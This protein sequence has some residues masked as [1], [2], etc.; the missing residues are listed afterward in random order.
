MGEIHLGLH[1]GTITYLNAATW[2]DLM[3]PPRVRMSAQMLATPLGTAF[4]EWNRANTA[5]IREYDRCQAA[6]A[7]RRT[8]HGAVA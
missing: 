2:A 8:G 1:T 7:R 3:D 4:D 5:A 6:R